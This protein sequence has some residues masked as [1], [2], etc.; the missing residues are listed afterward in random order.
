MDS[1]LSDDCRIRGRHDVNKKSLSSEVLLA[2]IDSSRVAKVR[3][4][5]SRSYSCNVSWHE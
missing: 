3:L 4:K 1:R 5:F 2:L